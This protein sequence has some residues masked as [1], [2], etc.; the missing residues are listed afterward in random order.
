MVL[1]I[2]S[3]QSGTNKDIDENIFL[4]D[5]EAQSALGENELPLSHS[6]EGQAVPS[7]NLSLVQTLTQD[8]VE[9]LY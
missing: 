4:Q 5:L 1:C 6:P 7:G 8:R 2:P 9:G 3:I